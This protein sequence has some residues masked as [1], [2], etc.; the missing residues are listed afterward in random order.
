M[1]LFELFIKIAVDDDASGNID[2]L[3]QKM[4]KGLQTA[5]KIGVAAVGT[6]ATAIAALTKT[7]VDSYAQYEQLVGGVDTLFKESSQRLKDYAAGAYLTAGMSANDYMAN[8][9]SFAASLISSLEGDTDAAVE[10]ANRAMVSMSDNA[11]K[12]GTN[13]DSIVQT[14]QSLARGNYMML[15]NLK[16]GYGGTKAELER[17]I[18]DAATYTDVQREMGVT[19]DAS[20]TSFDNIIN[21]IAVVQGHLGIAGATA[22][23]AA[24]TIEGSVNSMRAAWENLVTGIADENADLPDLMDKFVEAT[25]VAAENLVPRIGIAL[26]GVG[27]LINEAI[28]VLMETIPPIIASFAPQLLSAGVGV[29]E[30]ILMGIINN[31]GNVG[32][33]AAKTVDKLLDT[34]VD[35]LPL[36]VEAGISLI[37][38]LLAGAILAVPRLIE[39]GPEIFNA[40][41]DGLISI[42]GKLQAESEKIPE[43]IKQG[44]SRGWSNLKSWFNDLW[45]SLFG[46]LNVDV[47][48]NS[49]GGSGINSSNA[50]GLPYVPF[51]GYIAE[52][53]RGERVLTAIE[54]KKYNSG[55]GKNGTFGDVN[56]TVYG[57]NYGTP[58]ELAQAISEELQMLTE[59]KAAVYA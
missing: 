9:T 25:G 29:V 8:A 39:L 14:Y 3:S 7:S 44:I 33:G 38:Q 23:E 4:G 56:I 37:G 26:E 24:T 40:I 12:M 28:P 41:V 35:M 58:R 48:V 54:N 50:N 32:K 57:A 6:A 55:N 5:A 49:N 52:L 34:I 15:D 10:V 11:N 13:I 42:S 45:N 20:S 2:K 59:R 51:D 31:Q 18:A 46:N 47:N 1:N 30:S 27:G 16:L 43:W 36:L 53:H 21:A 17:L 22:A 19:V